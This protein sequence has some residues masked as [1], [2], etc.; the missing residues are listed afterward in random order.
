MNCIQITNP[1]G[2]FASQHAAKCNRCERPATAH[3]YFGFSCENVCQGCADRLGKRK[4]C[5]IESD[6]MVVR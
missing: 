4:D 1:A 3:A 2:G 5:Q 6:V